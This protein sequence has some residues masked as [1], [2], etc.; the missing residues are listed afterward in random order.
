MHTHRSLLERAVAI[1]NDGDLDG[2]VDLYT[3]DAVLSTP[4]GAFKGKNELRERFARELNALSDIRFDIISYVEGG[5]TFADEFLLAGTHTGP[6]SMPDGTELPA[7]GRHI[8]IRGM[9]MVQVR[10][11]RMVADN[12]YYDNAAVFAQLGVLPRRN[13]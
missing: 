13:D 1:Y 12:L 2:Y 7:T 3:D 11:G 9:E 10:D 5:D 8:E 4:E 6:L